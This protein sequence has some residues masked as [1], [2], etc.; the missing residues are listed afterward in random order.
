MVNL[1]GRHQSEQGPGGL[2]SRAR[3]FL[4]TM[5]IEL[6][7][8]PVFSPAAVGILDLDEPSHGFAKLARALV[9]PG[10]IE[11]A[12]DGPGAVDVV[13]APAAVPAAVLHLGPAQIVERAPHRVAAL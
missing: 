9:D 13:H 1:A 11:R 7:A 5:V 12:Q 6:V 2:R 4:I 8:R 10:G 3:R